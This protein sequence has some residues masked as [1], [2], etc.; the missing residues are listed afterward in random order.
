MTKRFLF[1]PVSFD[2]VERFGEYI[3]GKKEVPKI[4][5]GSV[6]EGGPA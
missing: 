6:K 2:V 4:E 1:I 3:G 5:P